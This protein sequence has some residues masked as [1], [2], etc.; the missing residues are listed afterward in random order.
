MVSRCDRLGLGVW[1]VITGCGDS[2]GGSASAASTGEPPLTT[3]T[4]PTTGQTPTGG[5][6]GTGAEGTDSAAGTST[7][8][9]TTVA[10]TST[11]T[12]AATGG[13]ETTSGELVFCGDEPPAGY[14]GDFDA[15]CKSEPQIG[16]F[17]PVVEWKKVDWTVN[18]GAKAVMM[19]PIVVSL[20][21]DNMDGKI[22]GD[23]LPDLAYVTYGG[24][25]DQPGTVRAISGDGSKE[26]WSAVD[27]LCATSG[28]AAGDIDGDGMVELVGITHTLQVRAFEH[29]GAIKWTTGSYVGDMSYCYSTPAIADMDGD[30][31]PEVIAGRVILDAAG[32]QLGKGQ[33]GSG[34]AAFASA[35]FAA[36]IDGD[37]D[38]E[39]VVGNALYRIDGSAIW[40][41]GQTDGYP[42]VAD[43]DGDGKPEIVVSGFG[44]LRLQNGGGGTVWDVANPA[45]GGGPPTIADFDGDGE[46][47]IGVAGKTNYV[48]FETD[49]TVL[50]QQ[51]TQ[52]ASSSATGSSV[53]DFEGDGI[54]DVVYADET[55]LYV[56]S[57]K[58]G[59]IKL[60]YGEHASATIIEYPLVVDVDG[61][62]QV[63]I[64]VAHSGY[65]GP[66][67]GITV[68]GDMDQSWRPGRK[69]W[70]QHAYNITNVD[71][72]GGIPT[73]PDPNWL[74][75]N[76]FRSG[77]LSPPDGLAAPDLKL[78]APDACVNECL[79]G[80]QAVVWY[81]LA[82][83]GAGALTAGATVEVY[84]TSMG[85]EKLLATKQFD[86]V[87]AP[88]E[89]SEGQSVLVD[90]TGLDS[91]RM[92]AKPAEEEC[93]VDP[94]DE[95][96]LVPPFCTAPG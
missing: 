65:Q 23:D 29:D 34:A 75:Y 52:D 35:S 10:A 5:A 1:L 79:G 63:E 71:D 54:A 31:K 77:D 4:V 68:L 94:A 67:F 93:V 11:S 83:A 89:V 26:L 16:V 74:T 85:V 78:L 33:F 80:K 49:G 32:L 8:A 59:A 28:L 42:A 69:I 61:D 57:G 21:D 40:S 41:N 58:D 51:P 19:A 48:V 64:V 86:M 38:Q 73:L 36:D 95:L 46:P 92:V 18:P 15:N 6:T 84:G 37:G 20:D 62:D 81:Q 66:E 70:N 91:L 12:G 76:N 24:P 47:E 87:L 9:S 44:K 22:D 90:T 82:N 55:T 53:Y 96:L 50:W 17:K 27:G 14:V 45:Q 60:S 7:G 3:G 13:G 72:A 43:F 39:V 25:Q 30:G 2:G 88:G 56:Y